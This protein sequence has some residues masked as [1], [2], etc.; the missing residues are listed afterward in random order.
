MARYL[1]A[2]AHPITLGDGR[3]VGAAEAFDAETDK[4]VAA[5]L[6][7]GAVIETSAEPAPRSRGKETK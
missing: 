4:A 1:N 2:A 3:V 6:K 7:A 5:L